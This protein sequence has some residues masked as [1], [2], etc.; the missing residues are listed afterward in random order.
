MPDAWRAWTTIVAAGLILG[1]GDPAPGQD[2]PTEPPAEIDAAPAPDGVAPGADPG[3]D[4]RL[5][6]PLLGRRPGGPRER[7]PEGRMGGGRPEFSLSLT[8]EGMAT[9]RADAKGRSASHT[10]TRGGVELE[11]FIP[12]TEKLFITASL[13]YRRTSYDFNDAQTLI[14]GTTTGDP[15]DDFNTVSVSVQP[16]FS[17]NRDWSLFTLAFASAGWEDGADVGESWRFGGVVGASYR[18]SEDLSLGFGIGAT[19]QLEDDAFVI[20]FIRVDWQIA[21][22]WRFETRGIEGI[23]FYEATDE[24]D[25]FFRAAY[26]RA[27][28]R[29]DNNREVLPN[30]TKRDERLLVG[31]GVDW[32]P[33]QGLLLRVEAGAA[34]WQRFEYRDRSGGRVSN[35]ESDPA[36][37]VGVSLR[38]TF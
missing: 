14:P 32:R 31:L 35:T 33:A 5:S 7:Q 17:L 1:A 12:V 38:F 13:D 27:E 8:G 21:E 6:E 26:E 9:T 20:P 37:Y 25:V 36:A 30:G 18:F 16:I 3:V 29:L 15:F 10:M 19:S 11:A 4:P 34:A 24:L 2:E 22:K 23:L 28:F